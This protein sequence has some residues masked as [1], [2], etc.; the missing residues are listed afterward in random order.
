MFAVAGMYQMTVWAL[1]KHRNYKKDFSNYP[2]GR[3]A[4]L[5]FVL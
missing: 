2:K 3:K 1:A 4:I 5:P